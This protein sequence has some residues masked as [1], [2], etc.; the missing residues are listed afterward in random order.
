METKDAKVWVSEGTESLMAENYE[1]AAECFENASR[2]DSHNAEVFSLYGFAILNLAQIKQDA[3]LFEIAIE[4]FEK[5]TELQPDDAPD[6]FSVLCNWGTALCHLAEFEKNESKAV[7]LFE[8]ALKKYEIATQ[9]INE[10]RSIAFYDGGLVCC[11][12]AERKQKH[13]TEAVPLYEDAVKKF[14]EATQLNQCDTDTFYNWGNALYRLAELKDDV[15]LLE[16]ACEKYDKVMQ[17]N[18]NETDALYN[19]GNALYKIAEARQNE[20]FQKSFERFEDAF[21]KIV[22]TNVTNIDSYLNTLLIKGELYFF[23]KRPKEKVIECFKKSQKD[24]LGI[25]TFLYEKNREKIVETDILHS[26]VDLCEKDRTFFEKVTEKLPDGQRDILGIY[27][28]AYVRSIVIMGLLYMGDS[29][30]RRVAH[31]CRKDVSQTLLFESTSKFRLNAINYSNDPTEG[32]TLLNYLYR[33]NNYPIAENLN[34]EYEA[35]ASCFTFNH[36]NL[37]QFRLYGKEDGKEGTGVSLVFKDSFFCERAKMSFDLPKTQKSD[38]RWGDDKLALF[39]CIYIDP[40]TEQP[41]V[42]VG[43]QEE[44]FFHRQNCGDIFKG[45]TAKMDEFINHI[46][47]EIGELKDLVKGLDSATVGRL[48]I[49]LRYLTKHIAFKDEH[50][51][52]IVS[53]RNLSRDDSI[54]VEKDFNRMYIEYSPNVKDHVSNIYFGPKA[55]GI[56]LF[57]SLLKNKGLDRIRCEKSKNPL[58]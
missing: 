12:L 47:K 10:D 32:K 43:Q 52:R 24:I 54:I 9:I 18:P 7:S 14:A 5:A 19:W 22:V 6:R 28:N 20:V 53:I 16:E 44:Y 34:D 36:D 27:K 40:E 26:L 56:E 21:E 48:L 55:S 25:L 4:N 50:E 38:K 39:R 30:E 17:M 31:Y 35:F 37:N 15:T 46:R 51:C 3:T 49:N 29:D 13:V 2:L 1:H 11:K 57:K 42:T 8:A 45:Y 58:A 41:I 33:E 23:L